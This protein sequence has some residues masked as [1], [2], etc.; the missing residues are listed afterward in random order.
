MTINVLIAEDLTMVAEFMIEFIDREP[1]MKVVGLAKN[2]LE[3]LTLY[4]Q[5]NPDIVVMDL[6]MPVMDGVQSISAIKAQNSSAKILI[7][8]ALGGQES[9]YRGLRAGANGF[10]FK[11]ES[12]HDLL[13][14]IRTVAS[15]LKYFSSELV[16]KFTD[17]STHDLLSEREIQILTTIASYSTNEAAIQLNVST[18]TI[19]WHI[20]R[21]L[22]KLGVK[23]RTQALDKVRQ[24]GLIP[25]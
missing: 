2:G 7:L 11:G 8:T 24:L 25:S 13:A 21:I 18:H 12:L 17:R 4:N 15:G 1:D 9:A 20:Q 10:L 16:A 23:N 22:H 5:L 6:A 3:A 14:A 19:H